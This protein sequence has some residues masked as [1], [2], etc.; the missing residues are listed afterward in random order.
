[1]ARYLPP[2]RSQTVGVAGKRLTPGRG[3]VRP[4]TP[5]PSAPAPVTPQQ[6]VVDPYDFSADPMLQRIRAS[7]Q[8][9]LQDAEAAAIRLRSEAELDYGD[10]QQ[11]LGRE[12]IEKPRALSNALNEQNLFYSGAFGKQQTDLARSLLETEAGAH[13]THTG[14]LGEIETGLLGARRSHEEG[15]AEAEEEAAERL[16][17]RLGDLPMTPSPVSPLARSLAGPRRTTASRHR[18]V[19]KGGVHVVRTPRRAGVF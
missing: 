10:I 12:R 19:G 11:K 16:R 17:E 8:A 4:R 5:A 6:P 9:R 3:Q 18:M 13:R 2:A 14:R 7:L 15:S 1:M